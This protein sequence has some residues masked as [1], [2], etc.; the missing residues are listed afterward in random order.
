MFMVQCYALFSLTYMQLCLQTHIQTHTHTHTCVHVWMD[1]NFIT[2][3][4]TH[5][6]FI[7]VQTHLSE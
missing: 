3:I 7:I 4:N 6:G 1:L 2:S 5:M